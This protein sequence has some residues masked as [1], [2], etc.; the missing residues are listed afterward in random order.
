MASRD[1]LTLGNNLDQSFEI[2]RMPVFPPLA[3]KESRPLYLAPSHITISR[4][5]ESVESYLSVHKDLLSEVWSSTNSSSLSAEPLVGLLVFLLLRGISNNKSPSLVINEFIRNRNH[6][7]TQCQATR[8]RDMVKQGLRSH[9]AAGVQRVG[10]FTVYLFQF[11]VIDEHPS[12]KT[13]LLSSSQTGTGAPEGLSEHFGLI[14]A[15]DPEVRYGAIHRGQLAAGLLALLSEPVFTA[16]D[17]SEHYSMSVCHTLECCVASLQ[18]KASFGL[19]RDAGLSSPSYRYVLILPSSTAAAHSFSP[20]IT[21]RGDEEKQ[22]APSF[23]YRRST[24]TLRELNIRSAY[25]GCGDGIIVVMENDSGES[26]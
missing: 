23:P 18:F 12:G 22:N 6:S 7:A 19:P 1:Y 14:K 15:F 9:G 4:L 8:Y 26:E 24:T 5:R 2:Y 11:P 3:Y 20:T 17:C 13:T 16:L 25:S 21:P 10:V